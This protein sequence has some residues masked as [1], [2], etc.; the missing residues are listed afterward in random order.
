MKYEWILNIIRIVFIL[1]LLFISSKYIFIYEYS[2]S[3][4]RKLEDINIYSEITVTI[5]ANDSFINENF[6]PQPYVEYGENNDIIM[7]WNETILDCSYMFFNTS[8]ETIDLSNFDTSK[9]TSMEYM[10]KDCSNLN[11]FNLKNNNLSNLKSMKGI[12]INCINLDNITFEN[13]D[14]NELTSLNEMFNNSLINNIELINL[15]FKKLTSLE[16]AF[17]NIN[18]LKTIQLTNIT[19]SELISMEEMFSNCSNLENATFINFEA[20]NLRNLKKMFDYCSILRYIKL[21]GILENIN[22]SKIETMENMFNNCSGIINFTLEN[23][24]FLEL[25]NMKNLFKKTNIKNLIFRNLFF[26]NLILMTPLINQ[27]EYRYQYNCLSITFENIN[28]PNVITFEEL[29]SSYCLGNIIFNN[30]T[31]PKVKSFFKM[32]YFQFTYD[33]SNYNITIENIYVPNVEKINY[34]IYCTP[35]NYNFFLVQNLKIYIFQNYN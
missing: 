21:D 1:S 20:N 8:I 31:I 14:F 3:N 13:I 4:K 34:M 29:F 27:S 18:S 28:I 23:I 35:S 12:F 26:P 17:S 33:P 6:T 16:K 15:N 10:F 7:R 2:I 19:A 24:T 5:D 32:F 9:V 22:I 30:I 11:Y 25:T